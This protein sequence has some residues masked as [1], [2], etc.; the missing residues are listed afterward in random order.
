MD[1]EFK[2][3]EDR[4]EFCAEMHKKLQE[5]YASDNETVEITKTEQF[6]LVRILEEYKIPKEVKS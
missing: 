2:S 4:W 1:L 3:A 5:A 6:R